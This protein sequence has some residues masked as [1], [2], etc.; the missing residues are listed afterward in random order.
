MDSDVNGSETNEV[1]KLLKAKAHG[2]L[3]EPI[4]WNF[5]KFL[6]DKDGNVVRYAPTTKPS[7]LKPEIEK[8]LAAQT[9]SEA[10][11]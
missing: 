6:V 3:G 9:A 7:S 8:L 4:A 10:K 1:F 11:I 5:T 2:V